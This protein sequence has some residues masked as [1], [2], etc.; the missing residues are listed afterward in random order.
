MKKQKAKAKLSLYKSS[1]QIK[2]NSRQNKKFRPLVLVENTLN[3]N[4]NFQ[5][6]TGTICTILYKTKAKSLESS[7][8]ISN[9]AVKYCYLFTLQNHVPKMA[10]SKI[11]I[12]LIH[13]NLVNTWGQNIKVQIH[14]NIN[15]FIKIYTSTTW[16]NHSN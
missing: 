11:H 3:Q 1:K 12:T 6:T 14:M 8:Q 5:L 2:S 4:S 10:S 15:S 13:I 9:S 16:S 7:Q